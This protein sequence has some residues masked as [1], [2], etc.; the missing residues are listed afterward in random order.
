MARR[1][2][3]PYFL[4]Q[5]SAM[6]MQN[7]A[8]GVMEMSLLWARTILMLL[9]KIKWALATVSLPVQI[10]FYPPYC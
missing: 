3:Q 6:V 8:L 5:R 1:W 7:Y 10:F 4:E 2:R 9:R